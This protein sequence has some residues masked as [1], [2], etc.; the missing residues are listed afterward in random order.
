VITTLVNVGLY[1]VGWVVAIRC[2]AAGLPGWAAAAPLGLAALHVALAKRT[3]NELRFLAVAGLIGV[4]VESLESALGA[5]APRGS[6]V[7]PGLP[8]L[9]LVAL[10]VQLATLVR[11]SLRRLDGR[12]LFA[13]FLGAAGGPLAFLVGERMGAAA[14]PNGP[15]YMVALLAPAWAVAT[16]VLFRLS[17]ALGRGDGIGA[18]R[19]GPQ[20][21]RTPAPR[22]RAS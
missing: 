11:F 17:R 6:G 9:W 2:A 13:A 22:P 14:F 16:P 4:V 21:A 1:Q 8:P 5:V 12:C 10:W 20:D 18:Y 7:L 15:R 3:A 19:F